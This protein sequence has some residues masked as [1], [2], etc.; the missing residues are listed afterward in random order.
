VATP[1]AKALAS[2]SSWSKR[3][4][5]ITA[6]VVFLGAV[7]YLGMDRPWISKPAVSPPMVPANTA[8]AANAVSAAFTPPPHS[9]AV[10]PFENLSGEKDQEYFSEGLTE[11]ILNSLTE[12]DGLQVSGRTSAFSFQGKDTDLGTI[13][14]KLDVGAVLEGSVRRSGR[15]VRITVQLINAVTGF[16]VWSKSYDRDLGDVLKLQTDIRRRAIRIP[17]T[18]TRR[19]ISTRYPWR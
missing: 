7:V 13:A 18:P 1:P 17:A 8:P 15:T 16:E 5:S 2:A 19:R 10:L 11:E 9:I 6:A 12:I 3:G 14:R 4:L